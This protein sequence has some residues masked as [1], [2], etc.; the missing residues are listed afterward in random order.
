ME[1][2]EG[3]KSG[4]EWNR[5][6]KLNF[7]KVQKILSAVGIFL[8]IILATNL[9]LING[10][11]PNSLTQNFGIVSIVFGIFSALIL[12]WAIR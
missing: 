9:F 12:F 5:K 11:S 7:L 8:S 6:E 3:S 10:L 4:G 1:A 2:I